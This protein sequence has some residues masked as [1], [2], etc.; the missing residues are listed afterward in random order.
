QNAENRRILGG[1]P[2][3][4]DIDGDGDDD[5]LLP[6]APGREVVPEWSEEGLEEEQRE[7]FFVM[8]SE[9]GVLQLPVKTNIKA[10]NAPQHTNPRVADFN[11]DGLADVLL[12]RAP[13]T[14]DA[15][16][17]W[18][19]AEKSQAGGTDFREVTIGAARVDCDDHM[20]FL[21][22]YNRDGRSDLLYS[23]GDTFRALYGDAD[24]SG[25][26]IY[27]TVDTGVPVP[28]FEFEQ[29][30]LG[31]ESCVGRNCNRAVLRQTNPVRV[32]DM[33]GDGLGDLLIN[34]GVGLS[35]VRWFNTGAGFVKE[36]TSSGSVLE[37]PGE[38]E[39]GY[40]F[41]SAVVVDHNHDGRQ[42]LL[43]PTGPGG[44]VQQGVDQTGEWVVLESTDDGFD[45]IKTGIT[46]YVGGWDT[47]HVLPKV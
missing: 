30:V 27:K 6:P 31:D 16:G 21:F 12:C 28:G 13:D 9:D 22:D 1:S 32:M 40:M 34:H 11:G 20:A 44:E 29:V 4:M 8:L 10:G 37:A 7:L 5:I 38:G 24:E 43:I 39:F 33:N 2:F 35:L 42:D 18:A 15:K 41:A 23:F 17:V 3:V 45:M 26:V 47:E 25:N 46:S 36:L 14:V 19:I